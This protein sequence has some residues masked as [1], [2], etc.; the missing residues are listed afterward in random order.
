MT[1][2]FSVFQFYRDAKDWW[3]F[4]FYFCVPVIFSAIFYGLMTG[5]M[6]RHRKGSLR[7][8]LSEHVKQVDAQTRRGAADLLMATQ[9]IRE[10]ASDAGFLSTAPRSGQSCVLPGSDLRS[11]LVPASLES[12]AEENRLQIP[13]CSPLRAAE[14]GVQ[15]HSQRRRGKTK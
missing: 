8:A 13:R 15:T 7:I 4:G 9:R 2:C 6:L 10:S 1:L 11:V 3:L 14:V 12:P 5:E